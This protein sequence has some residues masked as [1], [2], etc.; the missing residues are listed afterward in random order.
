[1]IFEDISLGKKDDSSVQL[2]FNGDKVNQYKLDEVLGVADMI[3]KRIR[4]QLEELYRDVSMV[5]SGLSDLNGLKD[6]LLSLKSDVAFIKRQIV[7]D[8]LID[9]EVSNNG[10]EKD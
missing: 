7:Q 6:F 3:G 9:M 8:E 10:I 1:M 2:D 5:K 4:P